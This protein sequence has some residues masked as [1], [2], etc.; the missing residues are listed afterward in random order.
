M[1]TPNTLVT[2]VSGVCLCV[3]AC[4]CA[5]VL[6]V[7]CV[8]VSNHLFHPRYDAHAMM[9]LSHGNVK[10]AGARL[11]IAERMLKVNLVSK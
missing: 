10:E 3:C 9:S 6:C 7:L 1:D 4:V 2:I 11:A 8:H 5:C